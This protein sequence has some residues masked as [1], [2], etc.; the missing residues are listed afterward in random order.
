M[1]V[2]LPEVRGEPFDEAVLGNAE[3]EFAKIA[4]AAAPE[5][6]GEDPVVVLVAQLQ[7]GIAPIEINVTVLDGFAIIAVHFQPDGNGVLFRHIPCEL[8]ADEPDVQR[9][10][11]GTG[12]LRGARLR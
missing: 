10:R 1:D 11:D 2:F 6:T 5:D 9:T 12:R 7:V 4:D 8:G 3:V